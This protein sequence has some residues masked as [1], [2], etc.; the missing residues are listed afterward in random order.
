M[1]FQLKRPLR[2]KR[3][4]IQSRHLAELES[5]DALTDRVMAAGMSQGE[6]ARFHSG[7]LTFLS[8]CK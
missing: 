5:D 1:R 4:G 8:L 7:L 2:R 6:T 3:N